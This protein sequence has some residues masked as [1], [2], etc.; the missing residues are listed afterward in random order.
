MM[1]SFLDPLVF[2]PSIVL[3]STI[4]HVYS[5]SI[6][7]AKLFHFAHYFFYFIIS[8]VLSTDKPMETVKFKNLLHCYAISISLI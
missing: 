8:T 5:H 2:I 3:L 4:Y 1:L 7:F 6:C